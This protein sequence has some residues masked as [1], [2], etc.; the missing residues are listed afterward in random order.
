MPTTYKQVLGTTKE[1][2]TYT[3]KVLQRVM[4]KQEAAEKN[5]TE[6]LRLLRKIDVWQEDHGKLHEAEVAEQKRKADTWRRALAACR[7]ECDREFFKLRSVFCGG[8][9]AADAGGAPEAG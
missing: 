1:A 8:E 6:M 7:A 3:V 2:L 4:L 5:Q 9:S